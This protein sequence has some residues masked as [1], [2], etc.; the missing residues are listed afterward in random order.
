MT[1]LVAITG[2]ASGIGRGT[3]KRFLEDGWTVI[4]LDVAEAGLADLRKTFAVH[5]GRLHTRTCDVTSPES[6]AAVF[7][8]IGRTFGH[9]NGLVCSA[10]VLKI[11]RLESMAG[12]RLR[13]GVL[14]QRAR[15][16]VVRARGDAA[17]QDCSQRG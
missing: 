8:E 7:A 3:A 5:A 17:A 10:G 6:I 16:V 13:S 12:R 11:G 4:A 1:G 9:I 15:P 14:G 2:G